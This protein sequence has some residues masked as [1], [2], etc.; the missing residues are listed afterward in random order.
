MELASVLQDSAN[1]DQCLQ[2]VPDSFM[3]SFFLVHITTELH[4]QGS[5]DPHDQ[6]EMLSVLFPQSRYQ[7]AQQGLSFYFLRR[8][9]SLL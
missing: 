2:A 4:Q 3:K 1:M 8:T 5:D 7:L 6:L 9:F